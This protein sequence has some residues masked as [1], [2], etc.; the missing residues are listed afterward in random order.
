[1]AKAAAVQTKAAPEPV[2]PSVPADPYGTDRIAVAL[3]AAQAEMKS[4][5]FNKKNPHFKN[6]Y[7]D[8]AAIREASIPVLT[9]HGLSISQMPHCDV[10]LL[11]VG[12]FVIRTTILHTS[13][14]SLEGDYPVAVGPAQKQGSDVTYAKRYSWSSAIGMVADEDDDGEVSRNT[15]APPPRNNGQSNGKSEPKQQEKADGQLTAEASQMMADRMIDDI[16]K[17]TSEADIDVYGGENVGTFKRLSEADR[18]R[19]TQASATMRKHLRGDQP[20]A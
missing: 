20:T 2:V 1:M 13:G 6:Q 10:E 17:K 7:A 19:V 5:A 12:Y 8:L 15:Q 9:K 16:G 3:A 14:Q 11:Q 4:A 18:N